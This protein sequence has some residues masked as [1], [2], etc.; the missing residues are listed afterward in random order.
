[1]H[2]SDYTKKNLFDWLCPRDLDYLAHGNILPWAT[3]KNCI[4]HSS[5][6]II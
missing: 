2:F 6:F 1:M 3:E 4:N 5:V